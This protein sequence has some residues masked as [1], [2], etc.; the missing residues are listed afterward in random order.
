MPHPFDHTSKDQSSEKVIN[1]KKKI[2]VL[3]KFIE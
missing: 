1:L 3:L 2:G